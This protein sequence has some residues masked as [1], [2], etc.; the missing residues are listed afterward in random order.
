[1]ARSAITGTSLVTTEETLNSAGTVSAT[2]TD[3][4]VPGSSVRTGPSFSPEG[5]MY[6]ISTS[7]VSLPGFCT[8][9]QVSKLPH[10]SAPVEPS[11]RYQVV[12]APETFCA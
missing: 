5:V 1:M 8:R 6:V 7:A 2:L 12:L 3:L 9:T 10:S 4:L 11:A